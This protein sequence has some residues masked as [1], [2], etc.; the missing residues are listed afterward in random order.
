MSLHAVGEGLADVAGPTEPG[1]QV[2]MD[3]IL[4]VHEV[5]SR[6]K[7]GVIRWILSI[8]DRRLIKGGF[9]ARA[10]PCSLRRAVTGEGATLTKPPYQATIATFPFEFTLHGSED[11][12]AKKATGNDANLGFEAQ[13]WAAADKLRGNMEPSDYK[14]VTLGLIFLKYISD[15]FEAKRAELLD[16]ELADAEDPE[17][18]LAENV[19]WVPKEARWSHLRASAK[20]PTIGKDIDG[21]MLA[22]EARN[23]S[24][25]G[26]LPK[27]YARPALNKIML[28][29]LIDLVS[30]IGMAEKADRSRDILGRVYEYFLGGFA[31]AEGKRGGEFYTPR[32]VVRLL[33]EMLEPYKGRVYDP[34]CGSGGMFVQSEKFVEEHGGRIGDIAIYGQES[35]YTTWRLAKMNLAVRGIDADIRWNN[36]GSFHKDE[37]PDLKADFILANPPFNVSD[38]GGDRVREDARWRFGVPPVGNANYAWLQHIHHHLALNGTAGVVLANGSMSSAQSGEGDIR[39]AMVEGDV[40]DC[41]IALPGQLFYSTQIPACL[42]FLARNKNLSNGWR[43]RRGEV[44][45][46]DARKLGHMVDRTR[47]EFSDKDIAR[48]AGTYNAWRSEEG[49]AEY[50]DVPGFCKSTPPNVVRDHDYVLTPGRYVGTEAHDDDNEPFGDKFRLLVAQF[51]EQRA[52]GA[53]LDEAIFANL[54]KFRYDV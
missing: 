41:M 23:A 43:D 17:E 40:V 26:V 13:L 49:T 51:R 30:G 35:N 5:L 14:H 39:R 36:E 15:A 24:L 2:H 11:Q 28:G 1:L 8:A 3:L 34:C 33:V 9:P 6:L 10:D 48:I 52:E 20:L 22:I 32:S 37:L 42:W 18:Y 31:G 45:F 54:R 16:E 12:M 7:S 19:F 46:I 27:D 50:A 25:K 44:L 53:K 38:W 21:A 4:E 47:K 29:E